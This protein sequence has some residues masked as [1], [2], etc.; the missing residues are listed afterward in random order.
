MGRSLHEAAESV[1]WRIDDVLA[2]SPD[3]HLVRSTSTGIARDGGGAFERTVWALRRFGADG[4]ITNWE[5]FDAGCEAEALARFDELAGGAEPEP[6]PDPFANAASRA[7]RKL[8]DCFNARDWAG[9]EALAAPDLVFDERRRMVRN[10]CGR[11]VWLAQFRILF[12]V[13]ASRFTTKLLATRGERLSLNLHCFTGEVA[14]GGGPLAMDDHCALHE[15][16][17]DGRIVAIVLF[18]LEDQDA[19]YAELDVRFAAGE[20]STNPRVARTLGGRRLLSAIDW[21][22]Y[23]ADLAPGFV[24]RDHRVL[25]F[26]TLNAES[27]VRMQESLR[28]LSPDARDRR[29]HIRIAECAAC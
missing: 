24:L 22:A 3:Q 16:D 13:P 26:G 28:D 12:D 6:A 5:I 15:V 4:R 8:F 25:G 1:R 27:F 20:A 23:A 10:S 9:I 2:L 19:A 7:D 21:R 14:G 18:D 17:R 11:D 29:E